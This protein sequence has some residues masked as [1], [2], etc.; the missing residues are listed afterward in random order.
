MTVGDVMSARAKGQEAALQKTKVDTAATR[1]KTAATQA[2]TAAT[3]AK[4]GPKTGDQV[5]VLSQ[6]RQIALAEM[7]AA[8]KAFDDV[9][10]S[11]ARKKLDDI[12][13]QLNQLK[14][15]AVNTP[16][17][18]QIKVGDVVTLKNGSRVKVTKIN[19]D[20]TFEHTPAQ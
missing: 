15:Q 13:G 18:P 10:Y 17:P 6:Q 19:P 2:N 8:T 11:A 3:R 9:G 5:K 20:G 4:G 16:P 14:T 12:D 1:A 7:N